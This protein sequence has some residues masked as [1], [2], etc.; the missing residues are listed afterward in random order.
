MASLTH[1]PMIM[2]HH[3]IINHQILK[4]ATHKNE[5]WA[6][7][8][9]CAKVVPA[10]EY[11]SHFKLFSSF[12]S[13][14][15]SI[16]SSPKNKSFLIYRVGFPIFQWMITIC[17]SC[18]MNA[19]SYSYFDYILMIITVRKLSRQDQFQTWT[20]MTVSSLHMCNY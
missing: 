20:L 1:V 11:F 15:V 13:E 4:S 19:L 17:H 8:V 5:K 3:Q 14:K 2:F 7:Q 10:L 16:I 6:W 12:N 9:N 18:I